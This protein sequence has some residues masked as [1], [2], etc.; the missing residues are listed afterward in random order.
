MEYH[1]IDE[2]TEIIKPQSF[3]PIAW[4]A[5]A[6]QRNGQRATS[7]P[8]FSILDTSSP[9]TS[10]T[11]MSPN[12][13][14]DRSPSTSVTDVCAEPFENLLDP[15]LLSLDMS[16]S[17]SSSPASS[18]GIK[19]PQHSEEDEV[20]LPSVHSLLNLSPR[21]SC[22]D[23]CNAQ[24]QKSLA[25]RALQIQGWAEVPRPDGSLSLLELSDPELDAQ[26]PAIG[27]VREEQRLAVF[28]LEDNPL[29]VSGE[30]ST[31]KRPRR[32]ADKCPRCGAD[33]PQ[34]SKRRRKRLNARE[35]R[36]FCGAHQLTD[37]LK[38]AEIEWAQRGYPR[39]GWRRLDAR[40]RK[41]APALRDI[42]N[43]GRPSFY[44]TELEA[45]VA[46]RENPKYRCM[47]NATAGY[48]GPRGQEVM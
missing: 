39:I 20:E 4:E 35:Q 32:G 48:Y 30:K 1:F 27:N 10:A 8:S 23:P 42:L 5:T 28:A 43:G 46:S 14:E 41:F 25:E 29:L 3:S 21:S 9:P 33:V 7:E 24:S 6:G 16:T 37:K 17:R 15:A 13:I 2:S 31:P 22:T 11:F 26:V 47:G 45:A 34:S 19:T 44:R 40:M 12:A 38:A 18:H 36:A